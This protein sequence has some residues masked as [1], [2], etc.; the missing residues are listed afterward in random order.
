MKAIPQRATLIMIGDVDQLPSVGAGNVLT[1]LIASEQVTVVTLTEIFRQ[2]QE[3]Y[4]VTNAHRINRGGFPQTTGPAD[5]NFFFMEEEDPDQAADLICDL[6]GK[7][8]PKHYGYHPMDDI[9][10]LCPMR[11]WYGW[12]RELQQ[13][14]AGN[15]QP[16]VGGGDSGRSKLSCRG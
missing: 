3:S 4:I 16:I 9:Q 7:R 11:R 8:L 12:F 13:T 5:R 10:V 1:D 14:V 15:S 2:A 6:V